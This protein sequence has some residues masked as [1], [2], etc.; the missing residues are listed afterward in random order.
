[1]G[2][3]PRIWLSGKDTFRLYNCHL[4]SIRLRKDYNDVLDSLIFNYSEKQLDDLKDLSSNE[5]GIYSKGITGG[6]SFR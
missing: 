3:L 4:Q 6:P 2:A 5:A 1:M